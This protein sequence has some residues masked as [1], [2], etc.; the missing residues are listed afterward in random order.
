MTRKS[1]F[2]NTSPSHYSGIFGSSVKGKLSGSEIP[3]FERERI[4]NFDQRRDWPKRG[5]LKQARRSIVKMAGGVLAMCLVWSV[6]LSAENLYLRDGSV[7]TGIRT[8]ETETAY[9]LVSASYGEIQVPKAE[10]LYLE[11][12]SPGIRTET[13]TLSRDGAV[14]LARFQRAVPTPVART[15]SFRLLIPG[16]VQ[17]VWDKGG[18]KI[19]FNKQE[20]AGNSLITIH[21]DRLAASTDVLTFTALQPQLLLQAPSGALTFRLR[22]V[23]DQA[24]TLKVIVTYPTDYSVTSVTPSPDIRLDGLIV[25]ENFLKRQQEFNPQA[26][27]VPGKE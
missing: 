11:T 26:V 6:T 18:R 14:V 16:S 5:V 8:R 15:G 13:F 21:Y 2:Q 19:P 27:L 1:Q 9:V 4:E 20:I 12:D 3:D 22:Y 23:P 17:S 10:V 25:W 24:E 7:L